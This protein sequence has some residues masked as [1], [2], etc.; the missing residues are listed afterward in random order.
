MEIN[1]TLVGQ[2]ITFA[3]L[4]WFTM[5]Y[6]WPPITK[7]LTEREKRIAAGLEASDR[8]K[9]ELE[10][11]E[12]KALNIIRDAKLEASQLVD[13]AHKRSVQIVEEA[14]ENARTESKRIVEHA[15]DQIALEV[16]QTKEALRR[17]LADLAILG[18]EKILKRHLDASAN[19]ALLDEFAAEI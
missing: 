18:A 9:R 14:K 16:S 7:A 3:L 19:A 6:V 2:L 13:Q 4:V 5:K 15:K 12:Q 1:A 8:S 10:E 17:Q 11:A